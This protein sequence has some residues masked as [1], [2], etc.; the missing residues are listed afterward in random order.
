MVGHIGIGV[1]CVSGW[2]D[3]LLFTTVQI[4]SINLLTHLRFIDQYQITF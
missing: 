3:C 1:S 2:S 4:N